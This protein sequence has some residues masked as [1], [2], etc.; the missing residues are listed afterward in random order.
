[1]NIKFF[2]SLSANTTYCAVKGFTFITFLSA[3][4]ALYKSFRKKDFPKR[5]LKFWNPLNHFPDLKS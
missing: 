5:H 2:Y 4:S 3:L 1:M